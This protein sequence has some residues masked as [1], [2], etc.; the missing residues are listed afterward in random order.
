MPWQ[1]PTLCIQTRTA[2]HTQHYN[3]SSKNTLFG[4]FSQ[5]FCLHQH[6]NNT[7]THT[8]AYEIYTI[9]NTSDEVAKAMQQKLFTNVLSTFALLSLLLHVSPIFLLSACCRPCSRASSL[10]SSS[11]FLKVYFSCSPPSFSAHHHTSSVHKVL[12]HSIRISF[13]TERNW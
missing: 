4:S 11:F 10:P 6:A 2:A 1:W 13:D 12:I 7:Y 3:G 5:I 9:Y 8:P